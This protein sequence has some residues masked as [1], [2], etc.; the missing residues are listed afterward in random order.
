MFTN[1]REVQKCQPKD[2]HVGQ[3]AEWDETEKATRLVA[4]G[5]R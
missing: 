2:W 4:L 5:H 3:K 1:V